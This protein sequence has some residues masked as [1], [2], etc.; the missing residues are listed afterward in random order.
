L[1]G[2]GYLISTISVFMLGIAAWPK[3]DDPAWQLWLVM[4]GMAASILGMFVRYLSHRQEKR[5]IDEAKRA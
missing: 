4:G 5:D 1:T 2:A 3:A